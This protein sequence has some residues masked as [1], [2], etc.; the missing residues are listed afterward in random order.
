[1]FGALFILFF[2]L[3]LRPYSRQLESVG[4]LVNL[5]QLNAAKQVWADEHGKTGNAVPT[6]ADVAPYLKGEAGW[7]RPVGG[8]QYTLN[9]LT[10]SPQA[11]LT[12]K[13]RNWPKGTTLR[14]TGTNSD[15]EIIL[16]MNGAAD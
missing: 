16:P 14:L 2:V 4:I 15:L 12:H 6:R 8:E 9:S 5:R 13:V 7:V 1:L 3:P 11:V 10:Q